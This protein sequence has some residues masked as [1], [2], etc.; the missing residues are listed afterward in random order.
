MIKQGVYLRDNTVITITEESSEILEKIILS[1][2]PPKYIDIKDISG[3]RTIV[4][5]TE[6]RKIQAN[7]MSEMYH[8][9]VK[10]SGK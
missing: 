2:E 6:I 5:T 7:K 3:S 8:N 10:N 4:A 9:A 1:P